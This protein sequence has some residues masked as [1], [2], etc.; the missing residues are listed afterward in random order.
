LEFYA[1]SS[2]LLVLFSVKTKITDCAIQR[3]YCTLYTYGVLYIFSLS[4]EPVQ[5][6]VVVPMEITFMDT[7]DEYYKYETLSPLRYIHLN[8]F[9]FLISSLGLPNIPSQEG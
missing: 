4:T 5:F 6:A 1:C 9:T 8:P 7:E 3:S 2:I